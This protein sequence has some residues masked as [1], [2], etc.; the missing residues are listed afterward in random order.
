MLTGP[1]DAKRALRALVRGGGSHGPAERDALVDRLLSLDLPA[2]ARIAGVIPLPGEPDLMPAWDGLHARGCALLM[3]ETTPRG[4]PLLFRRWHPEAVLVAGRHGTR[5]PDGPAVDL[6][7]GLELGPDLVFVPLLAW[8]RR[9]A[10]LGHGGGYYDRT[11]AA[12]P[13]MVAIGVGLAAQEV[14]MVPTGPYDVPLDAVLTERGVIL[15]EGCSVA[16]LVPGRH[17]RP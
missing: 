11:L 3:P 10:R 7:L 16:D 1:D 14:A 4:Q 13:D 5:H 8:D 17:R 12:R 15:P 9:L 2:G 6:E